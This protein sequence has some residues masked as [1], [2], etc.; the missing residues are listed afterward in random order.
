MGT[1]PIICPHPGFL[2]PPAYT[3]Y[4]P[5]PNNTIHG[6]ST[7]FAGYR[8]G[9]ID[10]LREVYWDNESIFY[11]IEWR[12]TLKSPH[13]DN[14]HR[15]RPGPKTKFILGRNKSNGQSFCA[16]EKSSNRRV[17]SDVTTVVVSINHR[18]HRNL[19]KRFESTDV[20]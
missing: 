15:T 7:P 18:S 9:Q 14:R 13:L 5:S 16:M 10:S 2:R 20:D 1:I 17:R 19:T 11:V 3:K 8:R 6:R 12:V 4:C